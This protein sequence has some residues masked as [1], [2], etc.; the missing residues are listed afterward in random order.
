MK[1]KIFLVLLIF[2][3]FS[4]APSEGSK[5]LKIAVIPKAT[6]GGFWQAVYQ[7]ASAKASDL[8]VEM[9][10]VGTE[11]EDQRVQQIALVESQL[12]S[13]VKGIALAPLDGQALIKPVREAKSAGVEVLIFDSALMDKSEPWLSFVAT[14]NEEGGRLAA[15][16]MVEILKGKGRVVLLRHQEGSASTTKREEGFLSELAKHPGIQVV[17]QEQY[18]GRAPQ[19]AAENLLLRF[20]EGETLA[21][22]GVF[23]SNLTT[24]YGMLQALRRARKTSEVALVGFDSDDSLLTALKKGEI[25]GLVVQDPRGMGAK[26]VETLV[27]HLR[28]EKVKR[29]VKTDLVFVTK[30]NLDEDKVKLV[31]GQ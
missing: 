18:G 7:G 27:G 9:L 4:C 17:S 29:K 8:G 16:K 1:N 28:G 6:T 10:W 21:F 24:T 26:A 22:E 20:G 13:G 2:L 12:L 19:S 31:L 14:D 3:Q 11:R 5:P 25:K 15:K 30:E 23:C